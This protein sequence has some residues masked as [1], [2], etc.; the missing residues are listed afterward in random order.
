MKT[1]LFKLLPLLLCAT[2]LHAQLNYNANN[3]NSIPPYTGKYLF[4]TNM[5]YYG[6]SWDDGTIADIAAGV[7]SKNV[8]GAGVKSL[9]P[10]LFE[11][12]VEQWGY[13]VR[14][15]EFNHYASLGMQDNTV[16]LGTP[17]SAPHKDNNKYGGCGNESLLFKNMYDPIWDGGA[18]GTPVNDNNYYAL[19]VYKVVSQYKQWVKFWEIVNEPD[20]D[21]GNSGWK[22]RGNAGN[23]W[24][25]N[26]TPCELLNTKAPI[27]HY[28]R[29]LRI[30]YEIIKTVDPTAYVALGGIGYPSYLDAVLRNTDDPNTGS[31]NAAYPFKGG[32][33][34]DCLSF[35]SYPIDLRYWDNSIGNFVS[36]RHS[37]AAINEYTNLKKS[38]DSVLNLYGYNGNTYPAKV[39]ICTENNIPRKSIGGVIGSDEAQRSYIIKAIV[40]SQKLNV[41]QM[42]VYGI[43][44]GEY[45]NLATNPHQM[46]GLYQAIGGGIGPLA[47]GGAYNQQYTDEG[48]AYKTS[49]DILYGLYYDAQRTTDMALPAGINGAAFTDG[50]GKYI[51]V[52][53][54]KTTVDN[55]E[56]AAANYSFPANVNVSPFLN[57]REWNFTLTQNTTTISNS[58]I[59]LNG[60]PVFL[61]DNFS[62]LALEDDSANTNPALIKS[63]KWSIY[64]NPVKDRTSLKLSLKKTQTISLSFYNAFGQQVWVP[65]QNKKFNR[66][67]FVEPVIIPATLPAGV[68]YLR[69]QA[70]DKIFTQK[71]VVSK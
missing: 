53:W 39:V 16:F 44:E 14:V 6:T 62:V 32:A 34:F 13:N 26:P 7:P 71:I 37:D 60:T 49:S 69:L 52:L 63:F 43:A 70:D 56:A 4:G 18:N 23:W 20:F 38:L 19:Y 10:S 61:S 1:K 11:Q 58:N 9:R 29:M 30:S 3:A 68:Y 12:F 2:T 64:P 25:N 17:V 36:S 51:Y 57:K 46:M 65:M 45:Y 24:E 41:K 8:K 21:A 31:S 5:G 35:H 28:I 48:I 47:N 22:P 15:N 55:S 40:Q 42:Y 54:A 67:E 66:G 27:F 50:T 33:Y 59:A